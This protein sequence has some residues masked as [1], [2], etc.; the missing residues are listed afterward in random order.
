M[1]ALV[2]VAIAVL[3]AGVFFSTSERD[4]QGSRLLLPTLTVQQNG[5]DGTD[6]SGTTSL[7]NTVSTTSNLPVDPK[8]QPADDVDGITQPDENTA[9]VSLE[10]A[11]PELPVIAADSGQRAMITL[12]G[13]CFWCTEAFMQETPGVVNAV[14][15]YAGGS[16]ETADYKTV[17]KGTT[18]HREA[19]QVTYDPVHISTEK[20]LD[21]YWAHIDP[22]DDGGQFADRGP[23]YRTAIFYHTADQRMIAEDSKARLEASGL[24]N[25]PIVTV[26]LPF[27]TFFKAEDYHQDY[28]QKA[29]DHY[30]RYK[31]ASG[32]AGFVEDTWAKDAALYF[33]G[34]EGGVS[35]ES[36]SVTEPAAALDV[37]TPQTYTAAEI[38][39]LQS[40]LDQNAYHI[41]VQDGTEPAFDNEYWDY[42]G[43]GIYVDVVTGDPLFSSTHKYDSK[44]GWPSFYETIA[45]APVV[46][47]VDTSHGMMRTEVRSVGG[48][49]GHLFSDG[50]KEYG[51]N[52]YCINS[53]ALMFIPKAELVERG[54]GDYQYLFE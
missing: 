10:P 25:K 24:F 13:G 17:S 50:P 48:H 53:A 26:I 14:S 42:K 31:Q 51:G 29:A 15:G 54:Y 43:A 7:F 46:T 34:Q 2:A 27:T 28:Y 22:T 3:G 44:T 32:R 1:L 38:A 30:E 20:V 35:A 33:L 21:V 47:K 45:G 19:V 49:L 11:S 9:S 52:R 5:E 41:V 40:Q 8:P 39:A 23:H 36:G 37:W 4:E 6:G 18:E 12:A 16:A